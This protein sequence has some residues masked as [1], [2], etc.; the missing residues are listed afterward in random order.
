MSRPANRAKTDH[1]TIAANARAERGRWL[2]AGV[3]PSSASAQSCARGVPRAQLM[4]AYEPAGAY[5]AYAAVHE[6]GYALWVRYVAGDEPVPALPDRMTVRIRHDGDEAGYSGVG[7]VTVTVSTRC[8]RCGGPR[9]FDAIRP[10]RFHHD[11]AWFV[12]DAWTNPCGHTDMYEAVLRESGDRQFQPLTAPAPVVNPAAGSPAGLI[13]AAAKA[14]RVHHAKQAAQLLDDHG[15]HAE[16]ELIRS[17]VKANHGHMSA[18][19]AA[20]FLTTNDQPEGGAR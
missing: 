18:K 15:H 17:Q 12:V 4:R 5:E 1:A 20:H 2:L 3:Y 10:H 9:G 19:Q 6:D 13:L 14:R 8:P 16:A 11:G 7:V